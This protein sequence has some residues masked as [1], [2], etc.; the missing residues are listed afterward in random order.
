M[1]NILKYRKLTR[2]FGEPGDPPPSPPPAV[3]P[4]SPPPPPPPPMLT[5]DQVNALI[6]KER[7]ETTQKMQA[8]IDKLKANGGNAAQLEETIKQLNNSLL[9]ESERAKQQADELKKGYER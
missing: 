6:A 9:S 2:W 4:V 5:Q 1:T 7:R 8:E 3:P